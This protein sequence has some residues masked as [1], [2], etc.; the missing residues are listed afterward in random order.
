MLFLDTLP[1]V[2]FFKMH[3]Q[4]V[5][6]IILDSEQGGEQLGISVLT[7]SELFYILAG[8]RGIEFAKACTD[9]IKAQLAVLNVD[10]QTA[11]KAGELKFRYAGKGKKGLPMAD[12]IIAATALELDAALVTSD[13]HFRKI[14]GLKIRWIY[15]EA[16]K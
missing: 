16:N 3:S 12:A 7:I 10:A 4:A 1:L 8:F 5:K 2:D 15:S 13:P 6:D 9:N 14:D 11:E